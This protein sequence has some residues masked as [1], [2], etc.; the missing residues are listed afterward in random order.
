MPWENSLD[1]HIWIFDVG[2]G[3]AGFIRTGLNHGFIIDMACSDEFSPA[4]FIRDAFSK[5][6]TKYKEDFRIAQAVL[7]HPH[8]DH[9]QECEHRRDEPLNPQLLTCPQDKQ[10]GEEVKWDRMKDDRE[11]SAELLQTY[12]AL[13]KE[14]K[15]PL[16]TI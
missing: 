7:S 14:R 1:T 4:E 10:A 11:G 13:F 12:R 3:N 2:R 15:P 6:L 5:R 8:R 16:Q 9:I